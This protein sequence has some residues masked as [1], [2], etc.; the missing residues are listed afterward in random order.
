[1]DDQTIRFEQQMKSGKKLYCTLKL[2]ASKS[3]PKK[4]G[5]PWSAG[6]SPICPVHALK[7]LVYLV[8]GLVPGAAGLTPSLAIYEEVRGQTPRSSWC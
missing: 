5:Q 6:A 2:S 7:R 1:M 4:G 8:R 3:D